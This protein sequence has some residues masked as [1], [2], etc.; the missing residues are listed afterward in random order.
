V[1]RAKQRHAGLEMVLGKPL[2]V[3]PKLAEVVC[4][5]IDETLAGIGWPLR[6]TAV[7]G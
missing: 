5:R 3:H 6:E 2:G 4:E 7:A 1:E